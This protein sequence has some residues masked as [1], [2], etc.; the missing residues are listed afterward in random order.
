MSLRFFADHCIPTSVIRVLRDAGHEVMLLRD[1]LPKNSPDPIV[2]GKA[3]ELPAI[4]VSL[5]GDFSDI[6]RYPPADYQGILAL[7]VR[8]HPE[9]IPVL[10]NRLLSFL[11]SHPDPAWYAGKLLLVEVHRIRIKQ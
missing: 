1:W 5:N 2:I 9:V 10:L 7:Q 11:A 8:D 6:V 4:L 3:Q